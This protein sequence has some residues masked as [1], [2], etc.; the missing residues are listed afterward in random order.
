MTLAELKE[1]KKT[2]QSEV[3][4]R[5]LSGEHLQRK[6]TED[7]RLSLLILPQLTELDGNNSQRSVELDEVS[8]VP[9]I[10]PLF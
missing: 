2:T 10:T 7:D 4:S 1:A 6:D 8:E 3:G 9:D 5:C